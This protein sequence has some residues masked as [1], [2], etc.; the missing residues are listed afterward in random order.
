[1]HCNYSKSIPQKFSMFSEF[2]CFFGLESECFLPLFRLIKK[3]KKQLISLP[4]FFLPSMSFFSSRG[5]EGPDPCNVQPQASQLAPARR[6]FEGWELLRAPGTFHQVPRP[7]E[8]A[9]VAFLC[10]EDWN[11]I[12]LLNLLNG[13]VMIYKGGSEPSERIR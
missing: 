12:L 10:R 9:E 13:N 8:K 6:C 1:M 2:S 11:Q 7:N 5:E 3:T 4:F